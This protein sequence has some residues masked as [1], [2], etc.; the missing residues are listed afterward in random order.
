MTFDEIWAQACALLQREGRVSYRALKRRL[1]LNDED[2]E[3]LKSELI[4]AKRLA[5][6]E[7]G[8]VLVW[9]GASLVSDSKFQVPGSQSLAPSPQTLDSRRQTLDSSRPEAERRQLTVMFCD[10]VGSTALSERLDPEELREVVRAYQQTSS[11]VIDHYDGHIAQHL[12]D[13][14]L[15]YFGYPMA[16]EDDAQRAVRAGLGIIEALQRLSHVGPKVPSPLAG[17]GQGEGVKI[18]TSALSSPHPNLP[19][20]GGKEQ[21][22][23]VRIGIHTGL[24][25]IGEIG[26]SEK[27]EILALGETPNIAAR[28]QGLAQPDTVVISSATYRLVEGLFEYRTLGPQTLRGVSTPVEVY[29][30]L[31][32]S[33]IQSRFEVA[34]STGLTPLVGR[35]QEAG[36]L[37][38]RWEQAK[39]G[40]GQVVLLSG[41]PGIGK[42]RLLQV[43]KERMANEIS[44]QL[45]CHCSPY[46]ENSALYPLIDLL[47]RVLQFKRDDSPE[48]K[49][50]KLE[51]GAIRESPLQA[52]V[53]PLL[54]S[55]LS[56][57]LPAR[58]PAITLTPQKQKEKT[59]QAILAWLLAEAER[60]PLRF[61]V[62]DLHWADP[63]TLE[64]LG[65]LLD[66]APTARLLIVLTFRPEF[67]PPWS[68][69]SYM[70]QL[71][72]SRLPRPQTAVMIEKLTGGKPLP[73]EVFQQIV[74]KTDG[75]PLF[76]EELTKTVLES[77]L[78]VGA[79][80]ASPIPPLT[81]P[82]T[83]HDSLMARLDRL[84]MAKEV[85]QLGA[86]LGREFSYELIQTVSPVDE[87][88]LQQALG[89]LVEAEVLYQRGLAPQARYLFKHA[90]I[91]DAAYQSLLKSIR[92]Q[93]HQQIAQVLEEQFAETKD[94]QPELLAHHYTE[95]GLR[96]QAVP[97]WQRAGERALTRSANIEAI[98][99]LTKGLEL[100]KTLPD[101]PERTQQELSLQVAL[102]APLIT[103]K[104]FAAPEVEQAH[105][106]AR[107][108]CRQ[109]GETPQ[110]FS[111]LSGLRAFYIARAELQTARALGEQLL[112]L[113]QSVQDPA[114]LLLAHLGLGAALLFLGELAAARE[115]FEQGM[116]LYDPQQHSPYAS[117]TPQDP[118]VVCLAYGAM[119]LRLLGYADQARRRSQEVLTL[120]QELAHPFSRAWA[121]I[122]AARVHQLCQ[123]GQAV[124]EQA[125]ALIALSTERGFP[126]MLAEGTIMRGWV[127]AEQGQREE[128]V[129]QMC[130]GLAAVRA[131]GAELWRPYFLALL[132]EAYG[133]VGQTEEGLTVLTEA[134]A[135][136][137]KNAD[138]LYEAELYRLKGE[139]TLQA[140]SQGPEPE[141]QK[142][143]ED[144][145]HKAIEIARRQQAKSLELRAVMSLSRL[146]QQQGKKEEARQM[147]A[148]IYGWFTEGFDTADLKE[149][150]A[151][152]DEL[153]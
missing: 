124:Q 130:Q 13:G 121:L 133:K 32:E 79:T 81:I 138:R 90:L 120:T 64:L 24:V 5:S 15:V 19:P 145:F 149:A 135:I 66:Q 10:L 106:R 52:E 67:L 51:V 55:L 139:L 8:K 91:Q 146:W 28:L 78:S 54:A 1:A 99:H 44:M 62:E 80:H 94:L 12:G 25:V 58:Y 131:M 21:S 109:V 151:L 96:E 119:V 83:L 57:S 93:Y 16:H 3:D 71:T 148:E 92:Q 22:L 118:G 74:S 153:S 143:A 76:V 141:N 38:E 134:L 53:I 14:L 50:R 35:E 48:E 114:L 98:G 23:Q 86:T 31:N 72:L 46:H 107:E 116:A 144:C 88:T 108:L 87:T 4:D 60:Q 7:D 30:V 27:R 34:V 100:L 11:A 6:D 70:T 101:T 56:L 42:S 73:P 129:T 49:L 89:K 152:L 45:E 47:Q 103:T 36:L 65:L 122:G 117:R 104:G 41:E 150:K 33:G 137:N 40:A 59:Q 26:S 126:H 142:Q 43:L 2:L 102:S 20:Q 69:R 97:Y 113:A 115:H 29:Q 136:A 17:E 77:D 61:N 95:A 127:L 110:L 123:E 18:T 125:E 68:P 140:N 111:V 105:S 147:L 84:G 37:L 63:S 39:E 128:G 85:A 112:S 82:A 75:V 9:T 132:A